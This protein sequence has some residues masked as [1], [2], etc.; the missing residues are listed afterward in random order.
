VVSPLVVLA[1]AACASGDPVEPVI[2]LVAEPAGPG[3]GCCTG[4]V[5]TGVGIG[6]TKSAASLRAKESA[7]SQCRANTGDPCCY[8]PE[9]ECG[10]ST[11]DLVCVCS[12]VAQG[13]RD[14]CA[15]ITCG[16]DACYKTVLGTD[17]QCDSCPEGY[18]CRYDEERCV[19][20]GA[21]ICGCVEGRCVDLDN[22]QLAC[23]PGACE[24]ACEQQNCTPCQNRQCGVDYGC[25]TPVTCGSCPPPS[26]C[27]ESIGRCY[28]QAC[29]PCETIQCGY[30]T[31]CGYWQYCGSC[32]SGYYCDVGGI[33]ASG[34][35][36]ICACGLYGYCE[37]ED[38]AW[39]GDPQCDAW[40]ES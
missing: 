26:L 13:K 4:A 6:L 14:A 35:T 11:G 17:W 30:D 21:R 15:G 20:D 10:C 28:Q 9:P 23:E 16:Y 2:A 5:V 40:C 25:G 29:F 8:S 22:P 19:L 31:H 1:L 33:C 3:E 27:D 18:A 37:D 12:V 24:P 32:P 39:C 36:R 34:G 7:D 38:G